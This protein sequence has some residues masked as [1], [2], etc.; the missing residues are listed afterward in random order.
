LNRLL[1]FYEQRHFSP[2]WIDHSP[3]RIPALLT[4]TASARDLGLRPTDYPLTALVKK[5]A[6]LSKRADSLDV[7]LK[8]TEL[9]IRFFNDIAT[10]NSPPGLG[11]NGSGYKPN[12][13]L[14]PALLAQHL[15]GDS[16]A[17]LAEKLMPALP[18][19]SA[20]L[21]QV[22]WF[23]KV[24][25]DTG[26]TEPLVTSN[27][28]DKNNIALITKLY[29]LGI[30]HHTTMPGGDSLKQ[31]T[32]KAQRQFNLMDDGVLRSTFLKELNVPVADRLQQL[33]VSLNYYRWLHCLVARDPVIVVNIPAAYLKVYQ[34][35]EV[36]LGMRII[37]GKPSTPTPTLLSKVDEVILYPYWHVPHSI[38]TKELLPLIKRNPGFIDA[39][40]YQVLDKSGNIMD[41]YAI[42]WRAFSTRYFPYLL[43][44]STGCDN[45]LGLLKF[46]FYSPF[47]VY[48]HDTP[49]KSL[50][51]LKKR[52]LSHGCMR[53]EEPTKL[54]HMIL[55]NNHLAIDSLEQNGCLRNQAPIVV[56]ADVHMPVLVWYN[57]AG[58]DADGKLV[59]YEDVYQRFNF[60]KKTSQR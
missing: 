4:V 5:L 53:L 13:D 9:A 17:R 31:A 15:A 21:K 18:E 46:N 7:E 22:K 57:P 34:A 60:K 39:G 52:H 51:M 38:A 56:H 54:G 14:V 41:P 2:A 33:R 43:R 59:Y 23:N 47:A 30:V 36:I 42:N 24:M 44:Q 8:I 20:L 26:Y 45:A 58:I 12:C 16:L 35:D 11:Y 6:F 27:K 25:P 50:F 19:I 1:G 10:G 3:S 37:A 32:R 49:M 29:L 28:A 40:N 48:L 55:K